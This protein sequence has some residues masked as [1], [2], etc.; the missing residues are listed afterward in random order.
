MD[1]QDGRWQ[2]ASGSSCT[3]CGTAPL[4]CWDQAWGIAFKCP[5]CGAEHYVSL[6]D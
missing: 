2:E 3:K 6:G 1:E 4:R 5:G